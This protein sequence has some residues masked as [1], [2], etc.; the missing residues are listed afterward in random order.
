MIKQI[1]Q[2][3]IL[4]SLTAVI[5]SGC[6]ISY[7]VDAS[8]DSIAASSSSIT[9][10]SDSSGSG[11]EEVEAA[12]Q[13]FQDDIKGLTLLFLQNDGAPRDFERQ[14]G[15]VATSYGIVDWEN[16]AATYYAIGS[17]LWQFGIEEPEV[18]VQ[19]FLHTAIMRHHRDLIA[20]GYRRGA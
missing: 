15:I 6:S 20:Q 19:P 14:L 16:E 10:F 17:G 1:V 18:G 9:S 12:L 5:I 3:I 11:K 13:R 4:G 2:Y 7:S 8:S